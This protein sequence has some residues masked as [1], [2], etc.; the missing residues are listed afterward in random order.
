MSLRELWAELAVRVRLQRPYKPEQLEILQAI[1][2]HWSVPWAALGFALIG[3]PL[4]LRPVRATTGIG[5]GLSLVIVFAYYVIYQTM[6]LVGE[7]GTLPPVVSAWLPNLVLMGAG[8][9]LFVN[10]RR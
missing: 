2:L 4:G 1:N 5:L 3:I 10:A 9:G 6:A 8:L 7:Q